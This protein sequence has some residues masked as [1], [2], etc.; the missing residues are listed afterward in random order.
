VVGLYSLN[1]TKEEKKMEILGIVVIAVI[2]GM[3]YGL[4][5]SL[6]TASRMG[7]RRVS[8]LERDQK[9]ALIK[10]NASRSVDVALVDK[11]K[12]N[13]SAIDSIEL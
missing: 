3:Y 4:F 11:A 12:A 8:D 9:E 13:I 1:K 6:E 5:D 10:K 7:N 2:V